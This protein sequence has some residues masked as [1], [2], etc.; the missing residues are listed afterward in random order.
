MAPI[1]E[2]VKMKKFLDLKLFQGL[3]LF[4]SVKITGAPNPG[5]SS[6][7]AIKAIE[8][9]A[10]ENLPVGYGYE[11]SGMTREE[12]VQ[13]VKHCLFSYCVWYLFTSY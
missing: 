1:S 3:N 2:F 7:D 13:V 5:F 10:A 9:V 12:L 6:G 11:F 4:T 8:E